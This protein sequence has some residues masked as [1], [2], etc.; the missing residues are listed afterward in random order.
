MNKNFCVDLIVS[1][2]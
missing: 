2:L 1:K